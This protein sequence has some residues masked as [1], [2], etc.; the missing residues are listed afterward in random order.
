MSIEASR[1]GDVYETKIS[2]VLFLKLPQHV[3]TLS[4]LNRETHE[5]VATCTDTQMNGLAG[6]FRLLRQVVTAADIH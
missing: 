4:S 6:R 2:N 1:H 3:R 5:L